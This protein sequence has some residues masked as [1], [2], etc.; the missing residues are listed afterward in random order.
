MQLIKRL[1]SEE[2]GEDITEYA[3]IVGGIAIAVVV[4]VAAL[5]GSYSTWMGNMGT[6]IEGL[7]PGA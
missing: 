7:D 5:G 6:F 3:L 2:R 1:W 4:A